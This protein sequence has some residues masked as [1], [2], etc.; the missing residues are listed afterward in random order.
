MLWT[1]ANVLWVYSWIS[2]KLLTL[3][4][5]L[6]FYGIRGLALDWFW[7]FVLTPISC[8][9]NVCTFINSQ[10]ICLLNC[11]INFSVM[12]QLYMNMIQDQP[13][14]ITFIYNSR[15]PPEV[16]KPLVILEPISGTLFFHIL[17]PTVQL[18][19]SKSSVQHY[20]SFRKRT[21]QF[22]FRPTWIV[23]ILVCLNVYAY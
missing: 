15:E 5:K 6:C 3:L 8:P 21:Y 20:S 22:E 7:S 1:M 17:K 23:S 19:H 16:R 11:F 12:L 9:W 4:D 2:K 13:V 14:Q 18:V 10:R